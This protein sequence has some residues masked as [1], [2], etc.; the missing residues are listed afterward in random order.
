MAT[1]V[2]EIPVGDRGTD[3]TLA[4]MRKL[5][6]GGLLDPVVRRQASS[7]ISGC[8]P[9][10]FECHALS[11]RSWLARVWRFVR[12]P[13]GV[14]LIRSPQRLLDGFS[15]DGYIAGDCDDAAILGASLGKAIGLP[16]RFM[17]LGFP[18]TKGAFSH[19]FNEVWTGRR[20]LDFDVTRPPGASPVPSRV[21]M[22]RV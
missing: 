20:W 3:L 7:C 22:V 9:Y 17:V 12:D 19:V 14:E 11:I 8:H 16:A 4:A 21:K 1:E 13:A 5:V 10:R 6:N 15:R 18:A 2:V